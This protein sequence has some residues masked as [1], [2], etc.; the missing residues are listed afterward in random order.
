MPG[1][2]KPFVELL[3]SFGHQRELSLLV[4]LPVSLHP[5]RMPDLVTREYA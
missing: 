3:E 5:P 1:A 2:A 4:T